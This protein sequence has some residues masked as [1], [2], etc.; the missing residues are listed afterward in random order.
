MISG[1]NE[2]GQNSMTNEQLRDYAVRQKR[3]V[4]IIGETSD[5]VQ[6][7]HMENHVQS[8]ERLQKKISS[9]TFKIMVMG[10]FKN[11]KSTFINAFL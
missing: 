7:L 8:L 2:E 11:G 3:L 9:E 1:E 10:N 4:D 6:I 5:Q